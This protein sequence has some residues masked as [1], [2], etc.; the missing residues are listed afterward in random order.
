[1][2]EYVALLEQIAENPAKA[3]EDYTV[4]D[5]RNLKIKGNCI[6]P[7]NAFTQ[8]N[9]EQCSKS[10]VERFE[11]QVEKYGDRIAVK[12]QKGTMT[13]DELNKKANR[14]SNAISEKLQE[15]FAG[16]N[17]P[18]RNTVAL[19]FEHGDAVIAGIMGT[20]KS[21]SIYVPLDPG[22]PEDRLTYIL[23]N[24]E[25][26]IL[27]TDNTN[28]SLARKLSVKLKDGIRIIN[29]DNIDDSMPS[30]NPC[31]AIDHGEAAYILYT[32]GS[33]GN[34]KGVIQS[35]RNIM[36]FTSIYTNNLHIDRK[37]VV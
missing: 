3:M 28:L 12:S 33:T 14:I 27:I 31:I 34:P 30:G 22:Y 13:Y 7:A 35:H 32:S 6:R 9:K 11:E 21:S 17:R 23:E 36:Y 8:F 26:L 10:I 1:M 16:S 18:L 19:L 15:V 2:E 20:L 4:F 29:T 5:K 37:S 25:A 24:S